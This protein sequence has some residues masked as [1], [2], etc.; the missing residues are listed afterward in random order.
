MTGPL[1]CPHFSYARMQGQCDPLRLPKQVTRLP[2]RKVRSA[3]AR[4][5]AGT[6][7]PLVIIGTTLYYVAITFHHRVWY[8][9]LSVH[10]FDKIKVRTS[11]SPPRLP[12][13]QIL[14]LSQPPLLS[15]PRR[16]MVYSMTRPAYLMPW[17]PKHL[18]FRKFC[19]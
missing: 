14:F 9:A 11:S 12:L 2:S 6:W 8:R 3:R 19:R 16:K 13:C 10:V 17:E 1:C 15:N 18:H 4:L 7:R 5:F